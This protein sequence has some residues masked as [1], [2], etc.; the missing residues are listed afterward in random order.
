MNFE[1]PTEIV[2]IIDWQSIEAAP[3]FYQARQPHFL[4]YEGVQACDLE[5][6]RLPENFAALDIDTKKEAK[7]LYLRQSLSVL[8]RTFVHK[9]IPRL[10]KALEYQ[11]SPSYDLLLL[12]RNLLIDGEATYL[13]RVVELESTWFAKIRKLNKLQ[14][15][16][17]IMHSLFEHQ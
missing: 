17:T 16:S 15:A 3:L 1:A 5:R 4:D 7:S 6:P 2:G 12:A 11:E 14:D 10:Y 8:Y 9:H 13:A